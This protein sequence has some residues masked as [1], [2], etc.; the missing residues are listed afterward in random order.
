[1]KLDSYIFEFLG[2]TLKEVM[3]ESDLEDQLISKIEQFQLELGDGFCFEA[4]Q[5]RILI[6]GEHFLSIWFFIIEF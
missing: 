4:R 5:K 3:S 2:L 6:G 1:M